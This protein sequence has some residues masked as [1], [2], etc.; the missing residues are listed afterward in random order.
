MLVNLDKIRRL[1]AEGL[2][3]VGKNRADAARETGLEQPQISRFLSGERGKRGE[4]L[5]DMINLLAEV[6]EVDSSMFLSNP[7]QPVSNWPLISVIGIRSI[8]IGVATGPLGVEMIRNATTERIHLPVTD[9][10]C[11]AVRLAADVLTYS[12]G[13][14]LVVSPS[15]TL[16]PG[17]VV[18]VQVGPRTEIGVIQITREGAQLVAIGGFVF[19]PSEY[20]LLGRVIGSW[21]T[22]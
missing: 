16:E 6:A 19:E 10:N 17:H 18:A 8:P 3:R 11:Y 5:L 1:I 12:R 13:D 22:E 21:R 14:L 20:T 7:P 4:D 15:A 9:P 2:E